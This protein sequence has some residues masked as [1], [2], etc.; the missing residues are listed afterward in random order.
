MPAATSFTSSSVWLRGVVDLFASYGVDRERLFQA[1]GMDIAQLRDPHVRFTGAEVA[2]LWAL[3][4]AWSGEPALG[5]SDQDGT[6]YMNFDI[7]AQAMWPGPTLLHGLEG[8]SRYLQLID[9]SSAF[10]VE[11]VLEGAWLELLHGA[12]PNTP[13]QRFEFGALILLKLCRKVTRAKV[14]PLLIE[15]VAPEPADFHPYRMAFGCTL[16]FGQPVLRILLG[17]EDLALPLMRTSSP[18]AVQEQVIEN[19][20]ARST[21][22]ITS[23]RVSEEIIRRLHLGPPQPATVARVLELSEPAL[24]QKLQ[25][26]NSTF[27]RLLDEARR[28]LARAYLADAAYPLAQ[29]PSLLGYGANAEFAQ[30]CK[31][32][33]GMP[34]TAFRQM[35]Q[36][37]GV[38][39]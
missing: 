27:E 14:R 29:L 8:L 26:E 33:F 18:L 16:R 28:D 38:D 11:P 15:F 21:R 9:D 4:V 13:R 39:A 30:A 23:Y 19:R 25:A 32:W 31:A 2:R 3:A 35:L 17:K 24:R 34:P 22:K 6:R 1:A 20:L 7:P 37:G 5:L 36:T 10:R 12:D